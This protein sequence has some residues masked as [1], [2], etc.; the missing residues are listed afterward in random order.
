MINFSEN[1]ILTLYKLN[2]RNVLCLV[3]KSSKMCCPS[4]F[5]SLYTKRPHNKYTLRNEGILFVPRCRTK[6]SQFTIKYRAPH[7]WNC[8]LLENS[9][10]AKSESFPLLSA[11]DME[12]TE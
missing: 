10:I 12:F 11:V 8:I 9:N 1:K 7:L 3:Y 2:V 4:V 6:F 5:H